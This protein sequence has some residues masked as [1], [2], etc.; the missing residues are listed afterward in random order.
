MRRMPWIAALAGI[1]ILVGRT[2]AMEPDGTAT[3]VYPQATGCAS[4][5]QA[6][7]PPQTWGLPTLGPPASC[8]CGLHPRARG[9]CGPVC[10]AGPGYAV[11]GCCDHP[12]SCCDHVWDGYCQEK[13]RRLARWHY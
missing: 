9:L 13:A 5:G 3:A 8:P 2:I 7:Y 6:S 10:S 12:I 1:W 11:Q 4:C